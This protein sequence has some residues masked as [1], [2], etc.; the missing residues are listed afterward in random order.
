M[1]LKA[2]YRRGVL[3]AG[4][5]EAGRGC[6]AGPVFA[7]AVIL[8]EKF[9]D[10][11]LNDSKQLGE[12]T[13]LK[14]RRIIETEAISFG[15]GMADEKEIDSLNILNASLLAMHRAIDRLNPLPDHL[16]VDGRS[17]LSHRG[18][19]YT[20]VIRG[21][22]TYSSVAAASILAKTYRDDYMEKLHRCFPEY[23][24]NMNKGYATRFHR[25]AVMNHGLSIH[26]RRSF[27][28]LDSQMS[29]DIF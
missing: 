22:G 8:P 28:L 13:R 14:L 17:F 15:V 25:D 5:D 18:I 1:V 16:L 10:P 21:D 6:I 20:C 11:S 26:H 19:P 23:G 4:C 12:E 7:A 24:W 2:F 9:M 3:E 27:R 29:L